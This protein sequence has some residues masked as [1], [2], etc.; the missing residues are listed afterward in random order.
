MGSVALLAFILRLIVTVI[1]SDR[2]S[3]GSDLVFPV[4][5][6]S[7]ETLEVSDTLGFSV[8]NC[9][10]FVGSQCLPSAGQFINCIPFFPVKLLVLKLQQD[11]LAPSFSP[12]DIAGLF[13]TFHRSY[14]G[15]AQ[16]LKVPII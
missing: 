8:A 1:S 2:L 13:F 10:S 3:A 15:T 5:R 12:D 4:R 9:K 6:C 16:T 14:F 7:L 11:L